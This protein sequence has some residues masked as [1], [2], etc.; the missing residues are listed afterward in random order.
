M[1]NPHFKGYY[2]DGV[3]SGDWLEPAFFL[4]VGAGI[5]FVTALHPRAGAHSND[6]DMVAR[7]V[8]EAFGNLGRGAKTAVGYGH[9]Q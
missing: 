8:R 4:T 9:F 7:C 5:R 6:L 3:P 1:I 2:Q